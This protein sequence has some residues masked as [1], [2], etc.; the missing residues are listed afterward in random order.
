MKN[1]FFTLAAVILFVSCQKQPVQ[2]WK[3]D[4]H[5]L[6]LNKAHIKDA[7][8]NKVKASKP[9]LDSA[10]IGIAL[11]KDIVTDLVNTD[12]TVISF[13]PLYHTQYIPGEDAPYSQG[14]G[15]VS[16]S[17]VSSDGIPLAIG[18]YPYYK[19]ELIPL[20]VGLRISGNYV[21]NMSQARNLPNHPHIRICDAYLDVSVPIDTPY[22]FSANVVDTATFK[23]RFILVFK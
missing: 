18:C 2:D 8:D 4:E 3:P 17:N 11:H 20:L 14:A 23:H 9:T 12:E 1:L 10:T 7:I 22:H 21:F 13:N 6:L 5:A 19:K 15:T 16:L